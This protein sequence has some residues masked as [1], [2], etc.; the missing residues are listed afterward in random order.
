MPNPSQTYLPNFPLLSGLKMTKYVTRHY[1]NTILTLKHSQGA[2]LTWLISEYGPD[3]TIQ[4]STHLT[5]KYS[6][7]IIEANKEYNP[8]KPEAL[9]HTISL[10]RGDF[11]ALVK[12]HLIL[13]TR[14]KKLFIVN[15]M[16][17]YNKRISMSNVKEIART[18]DSFRNQ[19][20]VRDVAELGQILMEML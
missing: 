16:L 10:I 19:A 3:N 11:K 8:G 18:Y 6:K 4:Y 14:T 12:K 1:I 9:S 13:P 5:I 17:S 7:T 15:P 20:D 2:L